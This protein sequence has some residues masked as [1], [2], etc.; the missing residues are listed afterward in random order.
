MSEMSLTQILELVGELGDEPGERTPR[1]RFR[2]FLKEYIKKAGQ[3]RDYIQE[4]LGNK[5]EQYDRAFQDLVNHIG[6]L[7]GFDV[8]FG[9]YKGIPGEIGFDGLWKSPKTGFSIV[10]ECKKTEVFPIRTSILVGYVDGLISEKKIKSWDDAMGLYVVGQY[11][12]ELRQLENSILSEKRTHQLRIIEVESLLTLVELVTEYDVDHED[13][14]NL[15]KPPGPKIDPIISL[16]ARLVAEKTPAEKVPEEE[17]PAPKEE[18]SKASPQYWLTPVREEEEQSAEDVIK[19]LVGQEKIY[20]FGDRTPGR[21]HIRPGDW[22]CF[23]ASG[24]GVVAHAKVASF[25]ERK[26]HPKVRHSERYPWTFQ[27][28]EVHLYEKPIVIDAVLR[29]QMDAFQGRDPN[30]AWGWFVKSTRKISERD[31]KIL[32]GQ[33]TE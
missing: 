22:I 3:T 29:K 15:L 24:K 4:C 19:T 27:L 26:P 11:D 9:R 33:H 8:E 23:H 31:F 12:P 17:K 6:R 1:E 7:L 25:P 28:K 5:G 18:I 30:R 14:L 2:K 16:I 13:I 21:K 32:T 10:V 20:A